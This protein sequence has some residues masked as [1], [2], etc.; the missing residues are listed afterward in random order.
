[1][2]PR[3]VE[4]PRVVILV[5]YPNGLKALPQAKYPG[6]I[7][8]SGSWLAHITLVTVPPRGVSQSTKRKQ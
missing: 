1:M 5:K 4:Y 3:L 7:G 8:V 2:D 6:V